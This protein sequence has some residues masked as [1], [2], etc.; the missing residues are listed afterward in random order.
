M[1]DIGLALAL[2][3]TLV[4]AAGSVQQGQAAK[5]AGKYNQQ[6]AE[7]NAEL[8]ERRAQ[9]ALERGQQ[10]EQRKRQEVARIQGAQTAAMAANG[11]DITFG[12]PLDT[13]VDTATLGELDALTIRTNAY[14]EAYDHRVDAVNQRAGGTLERAKGDAAAKGG[15]LAAAGT[16]LTGAGK[17]YEGLNSKP[18]TATTPTTAKT[19]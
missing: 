15:Y 16:I 4:S 18:K 11:L 7:M 3:S 13:L 10:E 14:R 12:S 19:K 17:Y 8:S 5:A 6:V 9:D 2:G 1:C